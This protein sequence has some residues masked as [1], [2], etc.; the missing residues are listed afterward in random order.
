MSK[1]DR[2]ESQIENAQDTRDDAFWRAHNGVGLVWS[3]PN[4]SDEIMI[5]N[6][7]L[8]PGFHLLLD[9]AARFGLTRLV[10]TWEG[11]KTRMAESNLPE[12]RVQIQRVTPTVERCLAN[13]KEAVQRK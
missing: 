8:R 7:L 6:A 3:N 5:I 9:I 10:T 1:T 2:P 4:A 13:M 12:E 11:L